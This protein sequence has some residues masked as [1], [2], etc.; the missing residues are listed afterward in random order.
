MS[1]INEILDNAGDLPSSPAVIQR[2]LSLMADPGVDPER[3]LDVVKYDQSITVRII[4]MC[5]STI[6][7]GQ[8]PVATLTSRRFSMT[9]K[10]VTPEQAKRLLGDGAILVDIREADE[11]ARERIPGARHLP[12]SRL[13]EAEFALHE[14]KSDRSHVVL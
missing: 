8:T 7:E 2:V 14:G 13:D 12:L 11:R 9:L 10:T 5:N 4:K 3:I 1:L 6:P